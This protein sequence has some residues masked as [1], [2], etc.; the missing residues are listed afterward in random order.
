M[1]LSCRAKLVS[2]VKYFVSICTTKIQCIKFSAGVVCYVIDIMF[3]IL[4]QRYL[5]INAKKF[6]FYSA[7]I[8]WKALLLVLF[9][10]LTK[11]ALVTFFL[12]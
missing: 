10:L 8:H 12:I 3:L 11:S 5:I 9:D 4:I 1:P 6:P 2:Y 7:K